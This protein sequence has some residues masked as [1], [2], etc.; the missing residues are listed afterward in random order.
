MFDQKTTTE[1]K[2][3]VASQ[4]LNDIIAQKLPREAKILL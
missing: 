1:G 4:R 2:D 3:T